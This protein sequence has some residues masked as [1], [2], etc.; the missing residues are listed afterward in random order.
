M[1]LG[2][3]IGLMSIS[4]LLAELV[5]LHCTKEKKLYQKIKAD[6]VNGE[7]AEDAENGEDVEMADSENIP[8]FPVRLPASSEAASIK[9]KSI[10]SINQEVKL[11]L[12][13]HIQKF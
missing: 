2:G 12:N 7:G 8:K 10:D 3:G 13:G 11:K 6:E 9:S 4:V 5:M 1:T